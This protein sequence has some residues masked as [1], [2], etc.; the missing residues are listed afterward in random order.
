MVRVQAARPRSAQ[1]TG[2]DCQ[3]WQ[4]IT[5]GGP[6]S[7]VQG[8]GG[9]WV[10][11][12][13]SCMR[14]ATGAGCQLWQWMMLGG[15]PSAGV[16]SRQGERVCGGRQWQGGWREQKP[17]WLGRQPA[18]RQAPGANSGGCAWPL[19]CV[20]LQVVHGGAAPQAEAGAVRREVAVDASYLRIL[21]CSR[22]SRVSETKGAA[23]GGV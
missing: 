16:R 13:F 21:G 9:G 14:Q 19:A 15:A 23:G 18:R 7:A 6:P 11:G 1:A 22:C 3:S 20:V 17:V 2:A 4:W 12:E 8:V 10:G 5:S